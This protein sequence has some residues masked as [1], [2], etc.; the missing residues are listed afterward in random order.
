MAPSLPYSTPTPT[1]FPTLTP[2]ELPA[3]ADNINSVIDIANTRMA[4]LR[5]AHYSIDFPAV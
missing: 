1:P 2:A 4:A 5:T 3:I